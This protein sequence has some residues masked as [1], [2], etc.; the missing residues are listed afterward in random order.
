MSNYLCSIGQF[1][2]QEKRGGGDEGRGLA[3]QLVLPDGALHHELRQGVLLLVGVPGLGV[4]AEEMERVR[5]RHVEVER[6]EDLQLAR[7]DVFGRGGAVRDVDEVL[8]VWRINL[9]HL[10]MHTVKNQSFEAWVR[11]HSEQK[12]CFSPNTP[13]SPWLQ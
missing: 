3:R 9:L 7:L 8:K 2:R 10:G 5:P 4:A 6:G 13:D 1:E 11:F 12:G